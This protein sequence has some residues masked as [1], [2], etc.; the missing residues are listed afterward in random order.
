VLTD[1]AR[2][3]ARTATR[4][5]ASGHGSMKKQ[6]VGPSGVNIGAARKLLAGYV[7]EH[8]NAIT[9][10]LGHVHDFGK[11]ASGSSSSGSS[12]SSSSKSS[13]SKAAVTFGVAPLP[14]AMAYYDAF[15]MEPAYGPA[16]LVPR[17]PLRGDAAG[18]GV[19]STTAALRAGSPGAQTLAVG[20]SLGTHEGG[21]AHAASGGARASYPVYQYSSS[22][23]HSSGSSSSSHHSSSH[24]SSGH[25]K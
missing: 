17:M 16:G 5:E 7:T 15:M 23:K 4:P 18:E 21:T 6:R 20:H 22:S 25:H 3:A 2:E 24:S 12:S 14:P 19:V 8:P 11:K 9:A 1:E 10:A 13:S